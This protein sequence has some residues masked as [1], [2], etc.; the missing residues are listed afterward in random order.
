MFLFIISSERAFILRDER[1]KSQPLYLLKEKNFINIFS[2]Y[3]NFRQHFW[4]IKILKENVTWTTKCDFILIG[5]KN[6][7]LL[8]LNL[9]FSLR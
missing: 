1:V 8:S 7:I 6:E 2:P 5:T 3:K 9:I 4:S